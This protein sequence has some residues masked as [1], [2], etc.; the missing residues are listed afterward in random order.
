MFCSSSERDDA[1][2]HDSFLALQYLLDECV[3]SCLVLLEWRHPSARA[4]DAANKF[5]ESVVHVA[6]RTG[7]IDV[8]RFLVAN[9]GSL[10]CCD[11]LGRFPLHEV[12]WLVE[13]RFDIVRLFLDAN[14]RG[15]GRGRRG[16]VAVGDGAKAAVEDSDN[17]S[18]RD[19]AGVNL[20]LVTDKRG[21]TPLR[22]VKQASWP[23]WYAFFDE[24][25]DEY[26]PSLL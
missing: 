9:G 24:I 3:I 10:T 7:N 2:M 22:Y 17:D 1:L 11:D 19:D 5:G 21:C 26:W 14:K 25:V 13:P 15:S 8:L 23:Q 12:C 4:Q 18:S 20:L 6:C 16:D